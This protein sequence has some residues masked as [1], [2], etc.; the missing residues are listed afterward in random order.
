MPTLSYECGHK[1][2]LVWLKPCLDV[3]ALV[4]LMALMAS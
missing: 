3:P 4:R 2:F 1:R